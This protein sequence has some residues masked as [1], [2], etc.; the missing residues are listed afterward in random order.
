MGEESNDL[1][2][3]PAK[4]RKIENLHI[5]FWLV[6]DLCWCLILKPLGIAMIFPTLIVAIWI[7]WRNRHIVAELTHNA[8]IA[9]WIVANSMWMISEF[10]NVDEK[11][12]PYCIIPFSLGILILLY[13]YLIYSPLQKKKAK[14]AVEINKNAERS[15]YAASGIKH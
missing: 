13:Y 3:I 14:A 1:Y 8:A 7:A 10:Y 15:D 11:V 5:L 12:R 6:K 4:F 9:L 2:V